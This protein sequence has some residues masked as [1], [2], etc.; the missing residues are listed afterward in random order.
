MNK[1]SRAIESLIEEY[2][3]DY[4][5]EDLFDELDLEVADVITV[6]ISQGWIDERKIAEVF[7]LDV[8]PDEDD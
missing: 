5:L 3:S 8:D 7:D 2:L 1:Y 6:L 4:S